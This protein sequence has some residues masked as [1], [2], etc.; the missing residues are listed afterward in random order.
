MVITNSAN[1]GVSFFR[2][3]AVGTLTGGEYTLFVRHLSASPGAKVVL[4]T[5][6]FFW[7]TTFLQPEKMWIYIRGPSQITFAF[8]GN[9]WPP[10]PL[11]CTFYVVNYTF[12]WPP[13]HPKCKRN[14]WK[15]S[16]KTTSFSGQPLFSN[17]ITRTRFLEPLFL[18]HFSTS[19]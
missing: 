5:R 3:W 18:N 7:S 6:I 15:A 9:F 10:T 2:D 19:F 11:V 1:T 13:T 16:Y 17:Q 4:Q 14:L 8:F 12:S